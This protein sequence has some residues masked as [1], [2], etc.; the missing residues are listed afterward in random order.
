[1][2]KKLLLLAAVAALIGCTT[3][4]PTT[5]PDHE[6]YG[7]HE[8]PAYTQRSQAM[9]E[10][11]EKMCSDPGLS[12]IFAKAKKRAKARGEKR[13][14]VSIEPLEDNT[15]AGG[16]DYQSTGQIRLELKAALRKT[17]KF[18]IFDSAGHEKLIGTYERDANNGV[19]EDNSQV[20]GKYRPFDFLMYGELTKADTGMGSQYFFLNL[21]MTDAINGEEIWSD[22]I[23]LRR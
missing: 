8:T 18:T 20:F 23:K 21:R 7:S 19:K 12:T 17:G 16:S 13:P 6:A 9:S 2:S 14:A 1:M 15:Q 5:L 22:T 3:N 4:V 10:L 11:L